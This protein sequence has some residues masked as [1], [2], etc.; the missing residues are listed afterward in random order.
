MKFVKIDSKDKDEK[1]TEIVAKVVTAIPLSEEI[2][3]KLEDKLSRLTEKR[4]VLDK[5]I[6]DSVLGGIVVKIGGNVIDGSVKRKL[7]EIKN[8]LLEKIMVK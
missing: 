1:I 5:K 6:D 8:D 3:V 7:D 2:S 4:V